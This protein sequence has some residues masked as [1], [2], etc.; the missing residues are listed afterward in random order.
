MARNKIAVCDGWGGIIYLTEIEYRKRRR[1]FVRDLTDSAYNAER[2]YYYAKYDAIIP[3]HLYS[4]L[5]VAKS[6]FRKGWSSDLPRGARERASK[7]AFASL[8]REY[9]R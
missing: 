7:Y 9:A 8:Q 6:Y 4:G 2:Y 1:K 3:L 5:A